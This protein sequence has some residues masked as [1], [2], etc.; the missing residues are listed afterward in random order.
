MIFSSNIFMFLFLPI[1]LIGY[2]L[3]KKSYRNIFLFIMSLVFYAWGE[4]KFVF[5]MIGS[6]IFN[7]SAAV[8][9]E[10]FRLRQKLCKAILIIGIIGNLALL[11]V[12]KYF[13]FFIENI[14]R[15]GLNLSLAGIALPI[16]I[17][18]FTFQAMSYIID[19]YRQDVSVQRSFL[20]VGLYIALFPQL[21]AGPIIRYRTIGYQIESR[22]TSFDG[23]SEGVQRFIIGFSKKVLLAN[24][25]ALIADNAFGLP[26]IERSVVY[27]WL[28]AIAYSLQI[29][30]DF[31][32]YSDMAIGLGKMFGFKFPENFNYPY[33]SKSVSEF[34]RR[35]HIS[36]GQW[37][38]DYVYFPLG[39]SRVNT[40][41]RLV[42]NLFIVWALTGVWHGASW[43]F[44]F[45]G[46][47]YFVLIT[48]E[49][50]TGYPNKFRS[51][52]AKQLYRIFTILSVIGGWVLFRANGAKA[53]LGYVLSMFGL[54]GNSVFCANTF[55]TIREYWMFL[56]FSILC[57]TELFKK[58]RTR[59]DNSGNKILITSANIIS[60]CL[61]FFCF[62][63]A[64]SF[65]FISAHNPFIYFN[66]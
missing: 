59:I 57:S 55:F 8:L 2:F 43:N 66:F 54:V 47:L 58:V 52:L 18:F 64:I 27:A 21:I 50:L 37:F 56:L 6:I 26:D 48:F 63:W 9:I 33:L 30:F 16:G 14:N 20:F 65:I 51:S 1:T 45:W 46:L 11:F 36:L 53:A 24:N 4:H 41:L 38:R 49:K 3:I 42:S 60:T 15:L 25:M 17:S 35:W 61:C 40:K 10:K 32:G 13:D 31:S 39:G 29:F 5:A 62:I 22:I 19:V 34:W 44:V 28:G 23:F 7:Y 12:F